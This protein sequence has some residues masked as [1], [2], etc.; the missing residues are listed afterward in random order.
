MTN[1]KGALEALDNL[2]NAT[3]MSEGGLSALHMT[4]ELSRW[5]ATI[6]QALQALEQTKEWND[7]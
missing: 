7:A 5:C 3:G 2:Y 1:T 4:G 6:R